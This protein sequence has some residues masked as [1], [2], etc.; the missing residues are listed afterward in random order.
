MSKPNIEKVKSAE[1]RTLPIFAEFEELMNRI[2]ERAY[3]RFCDRGFSVG[4]D[5]DDWLLAEREICWPAAELDE[6]DDEF[7]LKVAMAGF[8]PDEI[9]VTATPRELIVKGIHEAKQKKTRED[10]I[11]R[12]LW[13]DFR[14][15]DI[16]RRVEL[17]SEV[18]VSRI[19]AELKRGMLEIEAPKLKAKAKKKTR[20]K[21]KVKKKAKA[22]TKKKVTTKKKATKKAPR[23][24]KVS[25]GD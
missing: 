6:D 18:D 22:K 19:S 13:S 7:E 25:T 4:N 11:G 3:K 2:R 8:E 1:D 24:V 17:P 15:E 20:K 14:R 21:A 5:L 23:R 9:T 12:V 16:Y 10:D